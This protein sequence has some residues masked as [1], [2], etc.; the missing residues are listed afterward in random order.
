VGGT[1]AGF[2]IR[3]NDE[4][5]TD[6]GSADN[7]TD[8]PIS[9]TFNPEGT[10]LLSI[11]DGQDATGRWTLSVTDDNSAGADIGTLQDWSLIVSY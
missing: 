6:I 11:F 2:Q 8:G 7:P 9:G 3:L 10:E 5:G 1:D 4:A